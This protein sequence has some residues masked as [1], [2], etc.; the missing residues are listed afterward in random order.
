[1]FSVGARPFNSRSRQLY[2]GWTLAQAGNNMWGKKKF[3]EMAAK[4]APDP[5]DRADARTWL[6]LF[7][8]RAKNDPEFKKMVRAAGKPYWKG[9]VAPALTDPQRKMMWEIFR[10]QV[11]FTTD[12]SSQVLSKMIR[13]APYPNWKFMVNYPDLG[14]PYAAPTNAEPWAT[15]GAKYRDSFRDIDDLGFAQRL[16]AVRARQQRMSADFPELGL[17][18]PIGYELGAPEQGGMEEANAGP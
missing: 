8:R 18:A 3:Y 1:M 9:A 5:E 16:A 14:I 12:K 17:P 4:Y 10:D 6:N 2:G 7:K 11:P 15:Y 13:S